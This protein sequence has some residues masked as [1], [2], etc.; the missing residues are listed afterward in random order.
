MLVHT[1]AP[2]GKLAYA[3]VDLLQY[4]HNSNLTVSIIIKVL[5]DFVIDRPL[6]KVLYLQMDNTAR[7]NKNKFVLSFCA[8]LVELAVFEK[9]CSCLYI[10]CSK[11]V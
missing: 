4:P 7:E 10:E 2:S 8:L 5:T 11:L 3:F 6:P 1:Q 9:V